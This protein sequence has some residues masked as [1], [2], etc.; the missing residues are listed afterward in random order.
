MTSQIGQTDFL[1]IRSLWPRCMYSFV[2][3][4]FDLT[5]I[6]END[7][8]TISSAAS[9]FWLLAVGARNGLCWN[10]CMLD[11]CGFIRKGE[12]NRLRMFRQL[13]VSRGNS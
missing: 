3:T 10:M 1:E 7:N 13:P 12:R 11:R 9:S 6:E 2:L 5:L 8:P 4:Q